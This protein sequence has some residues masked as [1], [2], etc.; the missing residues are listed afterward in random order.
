MSI[1]IQTQNLSCRLMV[2]QFNSLNIKKGETKFNFYVL[3][4]HKL[5]NPI[6]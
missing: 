5:F 6:S 4:N 2:S 3:A 1:K